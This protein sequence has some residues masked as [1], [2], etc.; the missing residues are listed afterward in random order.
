[1]NSKKGRDEEVKAAYYKPADSDSCTKPNH[2]HPRFSVDQEDEN[3]RISVPKIPKIYIPS[4]IIPP[5]SMSKEIGKIH[6]EVNGEVKSNTKSSPI[7]RPRAVI[8]SPDNDE[9]IGTINRNKEK[10]GTR[11]SKSHVQT[12]T[13]HSPQCK[14]IQTKDHTDTEK[15][16]D[17]TPRVRISQPASKGS[18][19]N[20]SFER[21]ISRGSRTRAD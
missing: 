9:M 1:M 7:L 12:P 5:A 8:S 21:G 17:G 3:P 18:A 6:R 13:R 10:K 4:V 14:N 20:I 16:K 2:V 15:P 11:A 19:K